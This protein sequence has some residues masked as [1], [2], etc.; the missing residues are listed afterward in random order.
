MATEQVA[1][2]L[3]PVFGNV[4]SIVLQICTFGVL[5]FCLTRRMQN[6]IHWGQA[7]LAQWIIVIIY[8]DSGLF[9]LS[10]AILLHGFSINSSQSICDGGIFICLVFYMSTKLLIYYF[11]VERA[12][13]VGGNR[14]GRF[15]TK[16]WLF[17]CLAM[18]APYG[19]CVVLQFVFRISY[20]NKDGMC[21]IGMQ[22]KAM[23]PLIIFE[24]IVNVYLTLLFIIPLRGMLSYQTNANPALKR[25]AYRSFFGSV[26]TLTTAVVNLTV[27]MILKGEPAWICFSCCNADVLFCVAV[28]HWA[29][30]K[31]D[32]PES[33]TNATTA[34]GK[35]GGVGTVDSK[36]YKSRHVSM[37]GKSQH[38]TEKG[39]A[40]S[41]V[42]TIPGAIITT[43]CIGGSS[44]DGSDG[45]RG[46]KDDEVELNHI[47]VQTVQT[48]EIEGDS[49]GKR[50][51]SDTSSEGGDDWVG[52]RRVV[53]GERIV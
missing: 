20:I 25:M 28:L 6:I 29:S 48:I 40:L 3:I 17:N 7:A 27:V 52:N 34:H 53:V 51:A 19:I 31:D 5:S 46:F 47:R 22:K 2:A 37:L 11:L 18:I 16:L 32:K 50:S 15:K 36:Y 42:N 45:R 1:P 41:G 49:E 23:L 39:T 10:A 38:D 8:I 13:V 33:S 43:D 30:S 24:V 12:Y 35:T 44:W 26:C 14:Q 4:I 21:I 9:V